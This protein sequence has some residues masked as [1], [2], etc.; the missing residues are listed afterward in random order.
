MSAYGDFWGFFYGAGFVLPPTGTLNTGMLTGPLMQGVSL[1]TNR[2]RFQ[3]TQPK[4]WVG[5]LTHQH[6][7]LTFGVNAGWFGFT[8]FDDRRF[9]LDIYAL[10]AYFQTGSSLAAGDVFATAGDDDGDIELFDGVIE[11]LDVRT[12]VP[13][14]P[15]FDPRGV[16]HGV[17]GELAE[18]SRGDPILQLTFVDETSL[19]QPFADVGVVSLFTTASY[20]ATGGFM[21][22]STVRG[23]ELLES[24]RRR[25]EPRVAPFDDSRYVTPTLSRDFAS[26]EHAQFMSARQ[27]MSGSTDVAPLA[28]YRSAAAGFVYGTTVNGTDSIAFG[29]LTRYRT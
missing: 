1:R 24:S 3:D 18:G 27:A 28:G 22:G 14:M 26:V 4:L 10:V 23:A 11:P 12:S 6:P 8:A 13:G 9:D 25:P 16:R 17:S 7:Q 21:S 5:D 19:P 2:D 20:V 15:G 29:D